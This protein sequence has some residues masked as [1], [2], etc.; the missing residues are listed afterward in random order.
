MSFEATAFQPKKVWI[1]VPLEISWF[2]NSENVWNLKIQQ[3]DQKLW[4]SEVCDA[5]IGASSQFSWYLGR[6]NSNFDPWI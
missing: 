1:W 3:S 2:P 6:S 5:S 4:L